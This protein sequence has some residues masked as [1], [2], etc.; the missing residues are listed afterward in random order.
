MQD[1][2][3]MYF[4][5]DVIEALQKAQQEV[6]ELYVESDSEPAEQDRDEETKSDIE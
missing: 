6:E 4:S 1:Y 3:A 5:L 2:K